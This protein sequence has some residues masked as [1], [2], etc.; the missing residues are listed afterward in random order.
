M[1]RVEAGVRPWSD[2]LAWEA[3]SAAHRT[4]DDGAGSGPGTVVPFRPVR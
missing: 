3:V 4:D 1:N 2:D